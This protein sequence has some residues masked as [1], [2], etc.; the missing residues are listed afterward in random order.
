M[1]RPLS[2]YRM[3]DPTGQDHDRFFTFKKD[4]TDEAK[5]FGLTEGDVVTIPDPVGFTEIVF[6][7]MTQWCKIANALLEAGAK[8]EALSE[9]QRD[10]VST[11][12]GR[13]MFGTGEAVKRNYI[14]VGAALP[15]PD[16]VGGEKKRKTS[17]S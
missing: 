17:S 13:T 3:P 6:Y 14:D 11:R 4:A 5:A 2:F 12:A 9:D 8:R 15:E 1:S 10:F 7:E 16:K